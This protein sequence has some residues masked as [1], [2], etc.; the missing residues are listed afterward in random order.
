MQALGVSA[1]N[2]TDAL[3]KQNQEVPAGRVERGNREELVRVVGRITD[4]AQF[5]EVIVANRDGQPVRL[6]E[7]ARVEDATEEERSLALVNGERAVSLDIVKVSGANTVAVADEVKEAIAELSAGARAGHH[8][9]HR[10]RQLRG[11]PPLGRRRHLRAAARRAADRPRRHAV[12][13]R[14]EGDGR[15]PRW[16][17]RCR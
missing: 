10:A 2:I 3:R 1:T 8:A 6:R 13:Q 16:R 9:A 15:S 14:L 7:V 4:A 17:C 12:P 11:D 5:A